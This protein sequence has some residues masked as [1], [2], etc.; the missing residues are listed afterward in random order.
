MFS[1]IFPVS[2]LYVR[3]GGETG[4][5]FTSAAPVSFSPWPPELRLERQ[6][7]YLSPLLVD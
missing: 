7:G 4:E 1:V 3:R 6:G 2:S 5:I